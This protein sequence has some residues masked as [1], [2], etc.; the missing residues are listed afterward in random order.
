MAKL[1][2]KLYVGPGGI[3][4]PAGERLV[5]GD[6]VPKEWPADVRQ[7][8]I[9]AGAVSTTKPED[10]PPAIEPQMVGPE[11]GP[12]V[13]VGPDAGEVDREARARRAAQ[14]DESAEVPWFTEP[15]EATL[16]WDSESD[17]RGWLHFMDP[18]GHK[19]VGPGQPGGR[20]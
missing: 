8:F 7:S 10:A 20:R 15:P 19:A 2:A 16:A 17:H 12:P 18:K 11:P 3:V 14:R 1:P 5:Y 6:V 4:G 9:D 13:A